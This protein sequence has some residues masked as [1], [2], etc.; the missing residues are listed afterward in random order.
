MTSEPTHP[1]EETAVLLD[2]VRAGDRGAADDLVR[3]FLPPLRRWAHGRLPRRARHL[4]ETEDL[5]QMTLIRALERVEGF[6]SRREGAFLAYLRRILLNALRDEIRR[7][8]RRGEH[9]DVDD[10][11]GEPPLVAEAV[12]T[13]VL[14]AYETAL[15]RLPEKVQEAIILRLEFQWSYAEIAEAVDSPSANAVRMTIS[16]GLV[17]LAEVMRDPE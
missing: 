6:E 8:D 5:V 12:G 10:S 17:E 11:E 9:L 16:R 7:V 13:E 15:A 3:R 2:R 4:A 14:V 1:L